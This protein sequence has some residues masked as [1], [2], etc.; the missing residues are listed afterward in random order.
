MK[1]T[2]R[3]FAEAVDRA[4]VAFQV[5]RPEPVHVRTLTIDFDARTFTIDRSSETQHRVSVS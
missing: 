5:S 2:K 1:I 3:A 4:V